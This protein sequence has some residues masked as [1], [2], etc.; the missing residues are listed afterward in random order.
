MRFAESLKRV[1]N[2]GVGFVR[3]KNRERYGTRSMQM[4]GT[5]RHMHLRHNRLQCLVTNR[6]EVHI[7]VLR[8]SIQALTAADHRAIH[9]LTA[10]SV[11]QISGYIATTND[12]DTHN[13]KLQ[14][15][16]DK[17]IITM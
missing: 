3:P 7:G 13:Y 8:D 17:H 11:V 6:I 16:I 9:T 15:D 12:D 5:R 4:E 14:Q 1:E 10:E 2:A